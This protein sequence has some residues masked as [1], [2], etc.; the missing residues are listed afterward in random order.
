MR[1]LMLG[2]A[3]ICCAFF[4]GLGATQTVMA[5]GNHSYIG[6]GT[7]ALYTTHIHNNTLDTSCQGNYDLKFRHRF[8]SV[9]EDELEFRDTRMT[10]DIDWGS[11]SGGTY[12]LGNYQNQSEYL[13]TFTL[14]MGLKDGKHY[15]T[16]SFNAD[17]E[18][19][20]TN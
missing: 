8:N 13:N 14:G 6:P 16:P 7:V 15:Y 5:H 10:P 12:R 1:K 19:S 2:L 9:E 4:V 20:H 11:A 17:L 3:A 18:L